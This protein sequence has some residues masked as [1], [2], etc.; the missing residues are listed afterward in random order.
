[1]RKEEPVSLIP[2]VNVNL[3]KDVTAGV[4]DTGGAPLL[5]KFSPNFL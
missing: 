5:D 4:V 1:M 2:V 3:M